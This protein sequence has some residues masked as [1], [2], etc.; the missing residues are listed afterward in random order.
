MLTVIETM[1]AGKCPKIELSASGHQALFDARLIN[2]MRHPVNTPKF[3]GKEALDKCF[4]EF[5]KMKTPTR[6]ALELMLPWFWRLSQS[7]QLE[8]KRADQS[9]GKA[10]GAADLASHLNV[11]SKKHKA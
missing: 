9:L 7:E 11:K 2:F 8:Y 5:S 6:A 1:C 3:F 10:T 4:A